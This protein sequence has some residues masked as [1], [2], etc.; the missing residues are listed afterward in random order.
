M[1][2]MVHVVSVKP[3]GGYRLQIKFDNAAKAPTI[4]RR[5]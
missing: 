3:L 2:E 1:M 4:S 5:W